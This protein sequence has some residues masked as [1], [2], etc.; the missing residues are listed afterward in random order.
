MSFTP[1]HCTNQECPYHTQDKGRFIKKGFYKIKRL[2]QRVRRYK[3]VHCHRSLCSRS[4]KSDFGHKKMDLNPKLQKLLVEGVTIRACSRILKMTYKN[5]YKKFLW[6]IQQVQIQKEKQNHSGQRNYTARELYLDEMETIHHTKC[7][8]LSIGIV[9]NERY[10]IMDLLVAQMP[11]KGRLAPFSVQKYGPRPDEREGMLRKLVEKVSQQ[12]SSV[13]Q[14]VRTDAKPSYKGLVR[15]FFPNSHH[16]IY[17][18]VEKERHRE[19]LHEKLHKKIYDPMFVLNQ[20]CAKLRSDIRRL[21]RR[22]WCTTK[23]IE[24]LQGHLNLYVQSQYN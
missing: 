16:E 19:K 12:L 8:P 6:L 5:T 9:V 13:P 7:K 18:R 17:N 10:E 22:S 14:V 15:N 4:F 1:Y 20:R 2:N 21:T 24:N 23:K 11:A 3:C